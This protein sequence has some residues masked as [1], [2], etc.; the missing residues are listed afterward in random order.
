MAAKVRCW[1]MLSR[2]SVFPC[3][4]SGCTGYRDRGAILSAQRFDYLGRL[5]HQ[6]RAGARR[7]GPRDRSAKGL[8]VL[9]D[10]GQTALPALASGARWKAD[11]CTALRSAP[12]RVGRM[13]AISRQQ[14]SRFVCSWSCIE[15]F[16][17]LARPERFERPTLRVVT[18]NIKQRFL[19]KSAAH[20]LWLRLRE[21]VASLDVLSRADVRTSP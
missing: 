2:K 20:I 3:D 7:G 6:T 8:V 14:R 10:G 18:Q 19:R 1:P 17:D 11:V 15:W 9:R 4:C 16:C 12:W 5:T 21:R 13:T